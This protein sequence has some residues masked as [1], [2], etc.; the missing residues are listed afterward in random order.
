MPGPIE[1]SSAP[2]ELATEIGFSCVLTFLP[3]GGLSAAKARVSF[4]DGGGI[5]G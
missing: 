5:G 2:D 1:L 3:G 4:F